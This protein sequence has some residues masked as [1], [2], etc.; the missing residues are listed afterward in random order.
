MAIYRRHT[1]EVLQIKQ[2]HTA[3]IYN[4]LLKDLRDKRLD[5][6]WDLMNELEWRVLVEGEELP[7]HATSH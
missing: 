1:G 5:Y 2:M 6:L 7:A 3:H 4:A